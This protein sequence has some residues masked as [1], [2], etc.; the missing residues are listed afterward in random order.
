MTSSTNTQQETPTP[1]SS[2]ELFPTIVSGILIGVDNIGSGLAFATLLFT[3]ALAAGL[4]IGIS[5]ILLGAMVF[6]IGLRSAQANAAGQVQEQGIAILSTALVAMTLHM[7]D[8]SETSLVATALAIIGGSSLVTGIVYI[9]FGRLH[10]G[11]FARFIPFPVVAGF[12]AG[13]GCLLV[14][15]AIAILTK[16]QTALTML[17]AA[18]H[19]NNALK[20]QIFTTIIFAV[21]IFIMLRRFSSPFVLPGILVG[22]VTLFYALCFLLG[23]DM[24]NARATGWLNDFA[25]SGTQHASISL[26]DLPGQV[27][28]SEVLSAMP[29]MVSIAAINTLGLL[30]NNSGLELYTGRDLD[31][32]RELRNSG[33][34]NLASGAMC[35]PSGFIGLGMTLMADEMGAKSRWV[36]FAAAVATGLGLFFAEPLIKTMPGFF[37]AGIVLFL[38]IDLIHEWLI[39]TRNRLPA[40]E[41]MI[42]FVIFVVISATGFLEGVAVGVFISIILFVINYSRLPVIHSVSTGAEKRSNVDRSVVET[43][44]LHQHGGAID[45]IEIQGYLFFGTATHIVD[46]IHERIIAENTEKL[47]FVIL[48]MR[49]VQGADSSAMVCFSKIKKLAEL[50][51]FHVVFSHISADL[52]ELLRHSGNDITSDDVLSRQPDLDNALNWCEEKLLAEAHAIAPFASELQ[53]HLQELIGEHPRIPDLLASMNCLQ[54]PSGSVLINKGDDARDVFFLDRGKIS[55]TTPLPDGGSLHLRTMT[56]G[57]IFGELALYS[58]HIRIADVVADGDVVVFELTFATLDLLERTDP[59][60]AILCHKLLARALAEKL[61][62]TT[63]SLRIAQQ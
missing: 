31:S 11:S 4:N 23:I 61:I 63:K 41:W 8:A 49:R 33:I 56:S 60:L 40:M 12:L 18:F 7:P 62:V 5:V 30:L 39:Q 48:D 6:A 50:N 3:G 17:N 13:T 44:H 52:M 1:K 35:A 14:V 25:V 57:A 9:A 36:G 16:E 59:E 24:D 54:L 46:N 34:A 47:K 51:A 15:G 27:V 2:S 32:N 42:I 55:V 20:G 43:R 53:H 38:G 37:T 58:N 45:I 28:W 29:L 21:T 22:S 26:A 19:A 10:M